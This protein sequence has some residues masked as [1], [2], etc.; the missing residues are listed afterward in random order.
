MMSFVVPALWLEVQSIIL[1]F[2]LE[3]AHNGVLRS[4]HTMGLVPATS[5]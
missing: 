5:P 2:S 4:A 1:D 3:L